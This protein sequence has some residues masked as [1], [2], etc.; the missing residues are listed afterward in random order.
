MEHGLGCEHLQYTKNPTSGSVNVILFKKQ[1][2]KK[3][4]TKQKKKQHL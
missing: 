2:N 4:K 1:K 3:N